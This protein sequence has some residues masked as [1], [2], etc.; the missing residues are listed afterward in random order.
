[1]CAC[2]RAV[3]APA[4]RKPL[5]AGSRR[6]RIPGLR[7]PGR[8]RRARNGATLE[9]HKAGWHWLQIGDLKAAERNFDAALKLTPDFYPA[10]RGSDTSHSPARITTPRWSTSIARSWRIPDTRRRSP[11]AARRC[12]RRVSETGTQEFRGR[13]RRRSDAPV[14]ARPDR[15]A[16]APRAAGRCGC[17]AEGGGG[18]K[19]ADARGVPAG[20][21]GSPQSPFLIASSRPS[22]GARAT[23]PRA[24]EHAQK[25]AGW[26][27]DARTLVLIGGDSRGAGRLRAGAARRSARPSLSSRTRRC[28]RADRGLR[29]KAASPPCRPS[30]SHRNVADRHARAARGPFGVRLDAAV[31]ARGATHRGRHHRHARPLGGAVDPVRHARRADEVYA[32]HTFQPDA[33]VRRGIWRRRRQP[34]AVAHRARES[35]ARRRP[36][37]TRGAGSRTCPGAPQLSGRLARR[38]SRRDDDGRRWQLPAAAPGDRGRGGGRGEEARGAGRTA[39]AR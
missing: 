32:N 35:A 22:N 14:P 19:L 26:S 33:I 9:R 10:E 28:R 8:A 3:L 39:S 16:P 17:S 31:Q 15:G 18:G 20:D 34:R 36:G 27:R 37:G 23:S 5:R 29:E 11:A 1:M 30:T 25:A 4:R 2:C 12:S 21:S 24:L 38:R 6:R 13:R 7:V